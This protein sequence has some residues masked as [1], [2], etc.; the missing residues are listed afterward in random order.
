MAFA[1][2]L[3]NPAMPQRVARRV[4]VNDMLDTFRKVRFCLFLSLDT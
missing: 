1:A 4:S 2:L 3:D